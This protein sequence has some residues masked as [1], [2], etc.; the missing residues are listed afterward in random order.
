MKT[1]QLTLCAAVEK[2]RAGEITSEDY[3][4]A[5]L[6]RVRRIE[7]RVRAFAWLD[8]ERA[9]E[10]ARLADEQR[11]A[12][13]AGGLLHG[14]P[15]GIKDIVETE[16]IP[17]GMGSP[18]FD[19]YV[20]R[21]SAAVVRR[22][23]AAGAFVLGKTVTAELA[24]F[25]PGPTRNP[26]NAAHTP[27]GSSM[28]SAAAVAAGM[29]PAALGTQ[30]NGSVIRPAAFCG[31]VGFKPSER[32]IARSGIQPFSPTLDQVGVFARTVADAALVAA[33]LLGRDPEDPSSVEPQA[34]LAEGLRALRPLALAPRLAAV[35][36]PVWPLA[37][38]AQQALFERNLGALRQAGA[39]VEE[40]D[41]GAGFARAHEMLRR[42]M[43]VEGARTLTALQERHRD[44]LSATLN[45][46][47]DEGRQIAESDY[48]EALAYRATLQ[49]ELQR[50]LA[51]Y[52]AIVTPP[53]RGEAPATIEHTGDPAFCTIWTLCG[54][55]A[56]TIPAGWGPNRL[57]LGL[58]IV[59]NRRD[60][61]RTL[62]VARWCAEAIGFDTGFPE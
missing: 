27:G 17:T 22:L 58:Q 47:I 7:P 6:E 40:I 46:L 28:G 13:T 36:S 30:T 37:E 53:A 49:S 55:P 56:V 52:D 44:R 12:A 25:H 2:I 54:A 60:D 48:R 10:K 1:Y 4:R 18:A 21:R 50:L 62:E 11:R 32:L 34:A 26:W 45:R 61:E 8:P 3:T 43:Y 20:P 41:L 19:G 5:V 29:T 57:P 31:C 24:Y 16:S 33:A 9:L 38:A 23:E 14:V 51:S 42:I 39:A 35:R 59:G 15:V